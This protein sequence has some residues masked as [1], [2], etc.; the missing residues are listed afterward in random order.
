M[1]IMIAATGVVLL[2]IAG[3]AHA[4][5]GR[6]DASGCHNDRKNGGR[7]CHGGSIAPVQ[8]QRA[9]RGNGTYFANGAAARAAGAAPVRAGQPGYGRQFDRDGDG[10]G[11]EN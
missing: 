11:C 4:H 2:G 6:T 9:Y 3:A 10:V 8:P 1:R 7:H 5:G